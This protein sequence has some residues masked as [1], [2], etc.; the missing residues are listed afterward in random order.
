VTT[1]LGLDLSLTGTGLA[2]WR[3]GRLGVT[4]V[5]TQP[6]GHD[7]NG[8]STPAR[9]LIL[10]RGLVR[11]LDADSMVCK[12]SR[13]ESLDVGGNS[14]LDLAALH[15]VADY[16]LAS[17]RV[18][19]AKVNVVHVKQFATGSA[20]A[21]KPAMLEAAQ[22]SFPLT[23]AND[24]EADALWLLAMALTHYGLPLFGVPVA[25]AIKVDK[26]TWPIWSGLKNYQG[27]N[28]CQT[29]RT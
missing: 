24:N 19:I 16:T 11:Q 29:S 22:R 3:D 21:D 5:R 13:I 4:T 12:E 9:H 23:V 17:R 25:R 1:V 7:H 15:G 26:V 20:R 8:W 18:P 28:L 2:W 14:A 6:V 10:M 27:G